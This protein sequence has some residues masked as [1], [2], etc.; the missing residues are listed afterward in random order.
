MS[1]TIVPF[2]EFDN[3]YVSCVM[4]KQGTTNGYVSLFSGSLCSYCKDE[5]IQ[6]VDS[7]IGRGYRRRTREERIIL[8]TFSRNRDKMFMFGEEVK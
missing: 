2:P 7:P 4:C 1:I 3:P 6:D 5:F 8:T